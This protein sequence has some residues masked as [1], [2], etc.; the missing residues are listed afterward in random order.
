MCAVQHC[1]ESYQGSAG[2]SPARCAAGHYCF[3]PV[4]T[5]VLMRDQCQTIEAQ[6]VA[7]WLGAGGNGCVLLG[8]T[9]REGWGQMLWSGVPEQAIGATARRPRPAGP[10]F[11]FVWLSPALWTGHVLLWLYVMRRAYLASEP[12][13]WYE[14]LSFAYSCLA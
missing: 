13:E 2:S 3:V 14:L 5:A 7:D 6:T 4:A 8:S 10:V 1:L 9:V 11:G 12:P